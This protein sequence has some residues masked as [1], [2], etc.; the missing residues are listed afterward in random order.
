MAADGQ[1]DAVGPESKTRTHRIRAMVRMSAGAVLIA[2]L[3]IA[4]SAQG[5]PS[6]LRVGPAATPTPAP[7]PT[8]WPGATL[9]LPGAPTDRA[10]RARTNLD[11]LFQGRIFTN[12]LSLQ[13]LQ[14]VIDFDRMARGAGADNRS[15]KQQCIDGE[16]RRNGGR[17]TRLAW[18]VIRLKCR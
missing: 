5:E 11:A 12:D 9:G 10:V 8:A 7:S 3:M 17:P 4:A 2:G 6:V 16:V 18:E 14:D 15:T 13:E 1:I